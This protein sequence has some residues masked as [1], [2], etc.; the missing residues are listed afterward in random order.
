MVPWKCIGVVLKTGQ[1]EMAPLLERVL[2]C[3][4]EHGLDAVLDEQAAG[5]QGTTGYSL[6]ETAARA[7]LVIVLGGDGTVLATARAIGSRDVPVLGINLGSL[8]FLTELAPDDVDQA[9][10]RVLDGDYAIQQRARLEVVTWEGEREVD[11]GLV[12]NDAVFSKGPD[13]ARLIELD[14]EVDERA[15]GSFRA[16]GLIVSTPTGSTAYNLSAGGPIV[17]PQVPAMLVTPICPHSLGQRPLV[18]SDQSRVVVRPR[19]G[20]EVHLTL[21]GQVGRALRTGEH[22]CITRSAYPLRFVGA[23]DRDPFDLLHHKLGWGRQ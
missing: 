20:D 15:I 23:S 19:D 16:D 7:D 1:R 8:G 9:L 5:T 3:A 13:V 14:A 22:V 12:L 6:A 10:G 17:D 18:I 21:D 11:A 2:R 4:A